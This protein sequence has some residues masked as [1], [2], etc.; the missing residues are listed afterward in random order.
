MTFGGGCNDNDGYGI[1]KK[2]FLMTMILEKN[3]DNPHR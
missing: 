1:L 3:I 2:K